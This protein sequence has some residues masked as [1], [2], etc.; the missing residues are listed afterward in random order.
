VNPILSAERCCQLFCQ[1]LF[2][3]FLFLYLCRYLNNTYMRRLGAGEL[4]RLGGMPLKRALSSSGVMYEASSSTTITR[5]VALDTWRPHRK[6]SPPKESAQPGE[7]QP[8]SSSG[9]STSNHPLPPTEMSVFTKF[10]SLFGSSSPPKT[11]ATPT[12]SQSALG[13]DAHRGDEALPKVDDTQN[14]IPWSCHERMDFYFS[15]WAPQGWVVREM[16]RENFISIQISPPTASA[17]SSS[18]IHGISITAFAYHKKVKHPDSGALLRSFVKR[19]SSQ[20]DPNLRLVQFYDEAAEAAA[21]EGGASTTP[22]EEVVDS[23][24]SVAHEV[25]RQIGGSVCEVSFAPRAGPTSPQRNPALG[26]C[27]A[28]YHPNG[29]FHYVVLAAVPSEEFQLVADQVKYAIMATRET[30]SPVADSS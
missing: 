12:V 26:V 25:G 10:R 5:E 8:A 20:V 27:R 19:F 18:P 21:A 24:V 22:K 15:F 16:V 30:M 9:G 13:A 11:A 17:G 23:S 3:Y 6:P 1:H 4:L 28:F 14:G 2:H 29:R 7:G